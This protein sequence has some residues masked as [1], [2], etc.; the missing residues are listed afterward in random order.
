MSK[1]KRKRYDELLEPMQAEL[2]AAARWIAATGQRL[3]VLFEGRD[4][5][6]K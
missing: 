1:L 6:G 3:V 5:A 4:T 2:I